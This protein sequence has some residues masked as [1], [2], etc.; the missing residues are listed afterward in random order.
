MDNVVKLSK[1]GAVAVVALEER[2]YGNTFTR[3]FIRDLKDTFSTIQQHPGIKV[4]MVHG[5]DNYFCC[6]GTKEELIELCEGF[7]QKQKEAS[8]QF[9]DLNFHD[10]LLRCEV[11][12]IAAMQGHA[13]GGGLAFGCFADIIVMGEQ[14]LYSA[15]FMKYGFS[16]GMGA[17]YILPKKLG[18]SL[19]AEMLLT[20]RNYYGRELKERGA[21]VKIVNKQEV[22]K[23]AMEIAKDL[24]DKPLLSL[25]VL[26]EHL[27]QQT[28]AEL[29]KAVAKE[30]EMHQ[31]TFAQP[32]VRTRIERLFGN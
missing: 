22:I 29:P 1:E 20:A 26:K 7:G 21:P 15:N 8:P 32:G 2:E 18:E 14:C 25:K 5:C 30:L 17:T 3:R 4:V 9:T 10:L 24:A 6:G 27:T 16:P 12:V 31:I 11:P 13:L 23:T 28:R 19:A